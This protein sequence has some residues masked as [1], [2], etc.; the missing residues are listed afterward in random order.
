M[1]VKY[2]QNPI[3]GIHNQP[4][5][6]F[7]WYNVT[8]KECIKSILDNF[9]FYVILGI[10]LAIVALFGLGITSEPLLSE[11]YY[12]E[13]SMTSEN[14][15]A[16]VSYEQS[17]SHRMVYRSISLSGLGLGILLFVYGLHS[18]IAK[19]IGDRKEAIPTKIIVNTKEMVKQIY[20]P[21]PAMKEMTEEIQ[22]LRQQE[23][24]PESQWLSEIYQHVLGDDRESR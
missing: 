1:H 12:L 6:D 13:T 7:Y 16:R 20:E 9:R 11:T 4:R 21:T 14:S 17:H 24:K 19:I 23:Q 8:M 15:I 10:I 18:N 22:T 2:N 5:P 3:L